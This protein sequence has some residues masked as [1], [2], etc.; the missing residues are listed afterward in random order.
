MFTI[1][2]LNQDRLSVFE[3]ADVKRFLE[4]VKIPLNLVLL[5][6]VGMIETQEDEIA[7][8][9]QGIEIDRLPFIREKLL[10]HEQLLSLSSSWAEKVFR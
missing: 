6:K 9:F 2:V 10:T 5:N 1:I 7:G 4:Q 3:S 8:N